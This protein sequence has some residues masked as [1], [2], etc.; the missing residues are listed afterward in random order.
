MFSK[1]SNLDGFGWVVYDLLFGQDKGWVKK[2]QAQHLAMSK[3]PQVLS[4]QADILVKK[5]TYEII[6]F[7]KFHE[8]S[9]KFLDFLPSFMLGNFFSYPPFT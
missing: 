5:P 1:P 8:D 6:I 7:N 9:R 2:L 4:D 3:N